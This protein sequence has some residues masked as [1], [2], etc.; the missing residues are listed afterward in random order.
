MH[1]VR[2]AIPGTASRI[3]ATVARIVAARSGRRIRYNTGSDPCWIGMSRYFT[4]LV[5][6]ASAREHALIQARRVHVEQSDPGY[7]VSADEGIQQLGQADAG[8]QVAAIMREILRD[9]VDLS[10]PLQLEQLRLADDIVERK[11]P[12]A[13]SHERNGAECAAVVQPS[14]TLR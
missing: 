12:M 3:R 4:S 10:R 11:R 8:A 7:P 9:Q 5:S 13:A 14:L 6:R 2:S 1:V